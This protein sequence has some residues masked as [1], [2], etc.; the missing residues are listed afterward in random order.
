MKQTDA[1][2]ACDDNN[3]NPIKIKS[4]HVNVSKM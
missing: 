4:K 1:K 3:G 2:L